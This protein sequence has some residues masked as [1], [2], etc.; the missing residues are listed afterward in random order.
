MLNK[1]VLT[2]A[3]VLSLSASGAMAQMGPGSGAK[4]VLAACKPDIA[5]LCGQVVPGQGRIMACIKEN[6]PQLSGH[7]RR[8]LR[9]R[10]SKLGCG[11]DER[12]Q[13]ECPIG[14]I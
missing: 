13:P 4:A 3:M 9:R 11:T 1:T 8:G 2:I 12:D 5:R 14:G 10:C 6:L 7:A